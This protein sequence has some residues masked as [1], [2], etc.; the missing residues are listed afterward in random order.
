MPYTIGHLIVTIAAFIMLLTLISGIITHKNPDRLFTLRAFKGQRSYLDFHNVSSGITLPFFLTMT[1]T[2]LAI[3]FYIVL[4]SGMKNC[5]RTI[6]FSI[7]KKFA[8]SMYWP[9]LRFR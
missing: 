6:P 1:F 5:I 4:P 8:Q 7:L 2:G 9:T 3:F